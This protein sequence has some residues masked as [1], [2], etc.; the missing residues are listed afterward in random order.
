MTT[1]RNERETEP[2]RSAES[3]LFAGESRDGCYLLE[4]SPVDYT[5]VMHAL[6]CT[7]TLVEERRGIAAAR[8]YDELYDRLIDWTRCVDL[9]IVE[10]G[11]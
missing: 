6:S 9:P 7:G 1:R 10:E 5:L 11:V 8:P 4:L 3:M 2:T